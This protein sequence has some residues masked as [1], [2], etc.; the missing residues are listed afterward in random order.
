MTPDMVIKL[1]EQSIYLI[2][3]ISAPLLLIALGVG[4]LV[5]VFQAMTQIQEQTLAFIPKILAV[6]LSLVIF[7]PWMLTMLLD[8]TRDLFEQLPR[9]IG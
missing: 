2:I 8:Y 3:L 9:F 4:L 6:F 7:G 1:A 5:S